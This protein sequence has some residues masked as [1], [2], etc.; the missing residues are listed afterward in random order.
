MYTVCLPQI[1]MQQEEKEQKAKSLGQA[2]GTVKWTLPCANSTI[3][4]LQTL[5]EKIARP[6]LRPEFV[7]RLA[8]TV[9]FYLDRITGKQCLQLRVKNPEAYNF[10]IK[11]LL[12]R[13]IKIY[14]NLDSGEFCDALAKDER[15]YNS[16][17]FK[18]TVQLITQKKVVAQ[19]L[20][21]SFAAMATR[22]ALAK[23]KIKK[24]EDFGEEI[25]EDLL[26]ILSVLPSFLFF[27]F[28]FFGF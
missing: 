24:E 17:L 28:L 4:L 6:F 3:T 7:D 13:L 18:K 15:S 25:P 23:E 5:S 11:M 19:A 22:V 27:S 2:E 14:V 21:D 20:A 12:G 26:G 16:T 1:S 9:N 8:S 10:N